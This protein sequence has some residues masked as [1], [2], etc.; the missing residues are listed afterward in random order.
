MGN[1]QALYCLSRWYAGDGLNKPR[2]EKTL[3][4]HAALKGYI[5]DMGDVAEEKRKE[6][7]E[8]L[9]AQ[10]Q[11]G[12]TKAQ[13]ELGRCYKEGIVVEKDTNTGDMWMN[14]AGVKV[15]ER[16]DIYEIHK[17]LETAY[18][19]GYL[20]Y[21]RLLPFYTDD[22]WSNINDCMAAAHAGNADAQCYLGQCYLVGNT[23]MLK[24]ISHPGIGDSDDARRAAW[25]QSQ[26]VT[27]EFQWDDLRYLEHSF[28]RLGWGEDE[29]VED[30][31]YKGYS[32]GALFKSD[33]IFKRDYAEAVKW[34][35]L[36]AKQGHIGAK[37]F[38]GSCYY[39]GLGVPQDY[40]TAIELWG[41][42][43]GISYEELITQLKV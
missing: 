1:A 41:G 13:Y 20:E 37:G 29:E 27:F 43:K 34:F 24:I 7:F 38:L 19:N 26:I 31:G 12:N 36:A 18:M 22:K 33:K 39:L 21:W 9:T 3:L 6:Y 42:P 15:V 2:R 16:G 30:E 4:T 25:F 10:A 40:R 11:I 28:H 14:K 17:A 32:I 23:N 35:K 5:V 8:I